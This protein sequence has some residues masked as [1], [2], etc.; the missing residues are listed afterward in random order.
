MIQYLNRILLDLKNK[1]IYAEDVIKLCESILAENNDE[2]IRLKCL[3]LLIETGVLNEKIFEIIENLLISDINP[4]IRKAAATY[5]GEKFIHKAL[6]PMKWVIRNETNLSCLISVIKTIVQIKTKES[7]KLLIDK[8]KEINESDF[9]DSHRQ[10]ENSKFQNILTRLINN[11]E[12]E[13]FTQKHLG[14]I[15]INFLIVSELI[16]T[17]YYVHFDLD[18][19]SSLIKKLDLSD[20]EFEVRGWKSEFKNEIHD[21]AKLEGLEYLKELESLD[22]S[23]NLIEDI[24]PLTHLANLKYLYLSNNKLDNP[25]NIRILKSMKN[26]K[27]IDIKGNQIASNLKSKDFHENVKMILSRNYYFR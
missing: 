4:H 16:N 9:I 26:L 25:E 3:N 27:Y 2:Q 13:T 10:Y 5:I 19:L 17:L 20:I 21:L 7:K 15:I 8:L 22:L 6:S 12:I 11:K 1:K 23:N 24:K 18:P 14:D